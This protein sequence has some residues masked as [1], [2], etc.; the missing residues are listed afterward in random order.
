M[1]SVG[2]HDTL[3]RR[4]NGRAC[5]EQSEG[6]EGWMACFKFLLKLVDTLD[7]RMEEWK[8]GGRPSFHPSIPLNCNL[9]T[10]VA[11]YETCRMETQSSLL[12]S[13]QM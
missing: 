4:K 5:P 10:R 3:C 11:S 12:P 9:L 6:M 1:M 8:D 13:F 2:K 7:G